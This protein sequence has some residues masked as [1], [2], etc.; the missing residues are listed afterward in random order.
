MMKTLFTMSELSVYLPQLPSMG[1][2]EGWATIR[3]QICKQKIKPVEVFYFKF[4]AGL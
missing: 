4:N 2:K 3:I 1:V